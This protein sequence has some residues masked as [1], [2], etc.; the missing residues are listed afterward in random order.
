MRFGQ[1]RFDGQDDQVGSFYG[2]G[3]TLRR[4]DRGVQALDSFERGGRRIRYGQIRCFHQCA[5][6]QSSGDGAADV[7]PS[8]NRDFHGFD[9]LF[10]Y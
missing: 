6:R 10:F 2:R 1:P 4:P 3:V 5:G 9:V 8:D 7:A